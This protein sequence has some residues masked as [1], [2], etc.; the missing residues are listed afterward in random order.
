M[1][2]RERRLRSG[3]CFCGL[4]CLGTVFASA[5]AEAENG[6]KC[7]RGQA[8][9]ARQVAE[10]LTMIREMR[11]FP[12]QAQT[13]TKNYNA[14]TLMRE[15]GRFFGWN[16]VEDEESPLARPRKIWKTW[17]AAERL[18]ILER[19]KRALLNSSAEP[20]PCLRKGFMTD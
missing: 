8:R 9:R 17:S 1:R 2:V 6:H 13:F 16:E 12:P 20:I 5:S 3:R 7:H 14:P 18:S 10:A 15:S 19:R 4:W 11:G